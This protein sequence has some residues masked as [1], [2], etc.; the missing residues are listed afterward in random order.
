MTST[1]LV[2]VIDTATDLS[3][4]VYVAVFIT[5]ESSLLL[6]RSDRINLFA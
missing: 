6:V 2:T 4:S 1:R 5:A 3:F